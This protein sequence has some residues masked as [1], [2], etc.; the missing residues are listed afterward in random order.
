MAEFSVYG[1]FDVPITTLPSGGHFIDEARLDELVEESPE[2]ERIGVYVFGVRTGGGTRPIY[3]GMTQSRK[4]IK[5]AFDKDKLNKD[6][7]V[8]Q[9]AH[10]RNARH[11]P[12]HANS[13]AGAAEQERCGKHRILPHRVG[14]RS[15]PG[16]D[17]HTRE[18]SADMGHQRGGARRPR[19]AIERGGRLQGY[20]GHV[21]AEQASREIEG[22]VM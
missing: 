12:D 17:Q 22:M 6:Q 19:T 16:F 3:V 14:A 8:H 21:G 4:L 15:Q 10:T 9:H 11:L 5:E 13:G 20:D 18:L 1:P 7:P 2:F